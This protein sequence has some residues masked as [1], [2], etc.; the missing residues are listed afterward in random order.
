MYKSILYIAF[1]SLILAFSVVAQSDPFLKTYQE[2]FEKNPKDV[3]FKVK[4]RNDQ[5]KFQQGEVISIELKFSTSTPNIYNFLNRTYD[6]SGRL[7]L[8]GF[9]VDKKDKTF[10]PLYDYFY[11]G[12]TFSMG[13]LFNVPTLSSSPQIISYELNEFLSFKEVGKYRLYIFSPRVS[14][15]KEGKSDVSAAFGGSSIPLSSNIVEFEILPADEK[16]QEEKFSEAKKDCKT[17]RYLG[18]KAAAKEM[19]IRFSRGDKSCEFESHIG[20]YGSPERKFIVDEMEKMLVSPDYAVTHNFFQMLLKLN[21][22]L[23]N[24]EPEKSESSFFGFGDNQENEKQNLIKLNYLEK[25]AK[26]LPNKTESAFKESLETYFSFHAEGE[27]SPTTDLTNALINSFSKLSKRTQWMILQNS[28]AKLKTPAMIPILQTIY[29][30]LSKAETDSSKQSNSEPF[31]D[32]YN[33]YLLNLSIQGIY[34][35]A[36]NTGKQIILDE[37]RRPNQRVYTSVLE[38]LPHD[39]PEV[40]KLLLEKLT[41]GNI[42]ADDLRSVFMLIDHYETPKLISKLRE[43]YADKTDKFECGAQIEILKIFLKS[44]TKFG[45]E[46]LDKAVKTDTEKGCIGANLANVINPHWSSE[47]ERI[48][49]SVLENDNLFVSRNAAELLGKYGSIETRDKIWK[50]LERFKKEIGKNGSS[51]KKDD[52]NNWQV[53]LAEWSFAVALS[54]SP[55]WRFDQE[56]NKRLSGLCLYDGCKEQVEILNKIF[57]KSAKIETSINAENQ[58]LFSVYQ[59]KNMSLDSLKKKLEQFPPDTK[60]TWISN[61]KNSNNEKNFQEIKEFVESRKMSLV[62]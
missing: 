60:L 22:Y 23:N 10:D 50:R 40:E 56:S 5:T 24:P 61:A 30:N 31:E 46:M 28:L 47:I 4:I 19:L 8:D 26:A 49:L 36:P 52:S 48:V 58:T 37:L 29:N 43:T 42:P 34:E 57:G 14:L 33:Q 3:D 44:D 9:I 51:E 25:F 15:K 45:E 21:Y 55:N 27:K 38:L 1:L 18:T 6:R 16:W 54:E 59:Y 17:L 13:G 62:K 11:R 12:G 2:R 39:S 53:S 7:H 32:S 41:G 35:L 20:L